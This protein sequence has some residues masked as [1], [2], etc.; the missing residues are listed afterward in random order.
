MHNDPDTIDIISMYVVYHNFTYHVDK[1]E[2]YNSDL[3]K[4][5]IQYFVPISNTYSHL[6][7]LVSNDELHI[8]HT[9]T[10]MSARSDFRRALQKGS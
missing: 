4:R 1:F 3:I 5:V 7:S 8:M 10:R 6:D 9:E 2:V